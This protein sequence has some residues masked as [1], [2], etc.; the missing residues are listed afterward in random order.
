M[1]LKRCPETRENLIADG[2]WQMANNK[3]AIGNF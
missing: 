3:S 2:K 1:S